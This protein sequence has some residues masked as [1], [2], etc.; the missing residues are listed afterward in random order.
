MVAVDTT[1]ALMYGFRLLGYLIAVFL[2]GAVLLGIGAGFS[3]GP[4][5]SGN[6]ILALLFI[7]AGAAVLYAGGLGIF[8]KVI[9][10]GVEKGNRA[11]SS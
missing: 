10:D 2:A 1:D 7:V 5:G 6:P 9:A 4:M 3:P 11:A 8:Y